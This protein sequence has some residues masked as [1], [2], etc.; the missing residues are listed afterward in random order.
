LKISVAVAEG[1]RS[2]EVRYY[3]DIDAT[4]ASVASLLKKLKK[5]GV[6]VRFC[7]E[8]GPTGYELSR[9]IAAG[10][11][12]CAVVAPSLIPSRPGDRV[13]TNRR[14]AINLAKLFRVVYVLWFIVVKAFGG[15]FAARKSSLQSWFVFA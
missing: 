7:Y 11:Y 5:R 4:P 12:E 9:Q 15:R 3:G 8:A 2:G 14:D 1:G 13:K 10:G 6:M